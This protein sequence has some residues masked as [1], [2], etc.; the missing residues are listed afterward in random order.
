MLTSPRYTR[1]CNNCN[2]QRVGELRNEFLPHFF[3]N[4]PNMYKFQQL[5]SSQDGK[6]IIKLFK[7]IKGGFNYTYNINN[8]LPNH[9]INVPL[10]NLST[11]VY[12]S[13]AFTIFF[14]ML[15][16]HHAL[17]SCIYMYFYV[18]HASTRGQS[19]NKP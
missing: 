1:Y 8:N 16:Y 3:T 19:Y 9:Y 7:F 13:R 10:L 4:N 18:L 15:L 11:N 17:Y 2:M 12:I 14:T 5:M 6:V